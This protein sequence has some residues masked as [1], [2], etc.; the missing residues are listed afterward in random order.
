MHLI[1]IRH[2]QSFVNLPDWDGGFVDAALTELGQQQ[3]ARA[4][5]WVRGRFAPD[6]IISSTMLRAMETA[7]H[8]GTALEMP[9]TPDDRLREIGNAWPD[10]TPVDLTKGEPRWSDFWAS[11]RPY[12]PICEGGESWGDF[13]TRVGRS[14]Y[15]AADRH[16]DSDDTV[17]VVC[18]GGVINAALDV[19]FNIGLWRSTDAWVHNTSI[20]HLEYKPPASR[21]E[22]WRLHGV[23]LAYHLMDPDGSLLGYEWKGRQPAD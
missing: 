21:Q 22:F 18:H 5:Q 2:G 11:E 1:L 7:E 8:I 10:A 19:A 9:I 17:L 16:P 3:A 6:E 15:E 23:N 20:T 14:L 13:I 4:A 12:S